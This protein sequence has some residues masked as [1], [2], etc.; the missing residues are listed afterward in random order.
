MKML[1]LVR[2]AILLSFLV[3]LVLAQR[4][5]FLGAWQWIGAIHRPALRN[6]LRIAWFAALLLFVAAFL[7]PIFGRFL[8]RAGG[9]KW[10]IAGARI[11]LI[12]SLFAFFAVK[13]VGALG[14]ISSFAT[15]AASTT[16]DPARR[17]FFRYAAYAAGSLPF[18]AASYGFASGRL[19]YRVERAEVPIADLPQG[20]DGPEDRAAE[21][22]PHR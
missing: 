18:V 14:W 11:W 20:L 7:D 12:A 21:R 1:D 2:S 9:G 4:F 15:S 8:P 5:W 22:H 17:K 10:I 19:K 13:F 16:F 3:L 6:L